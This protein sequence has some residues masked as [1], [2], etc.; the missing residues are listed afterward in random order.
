MISFIT[1]DQSIVEKLKIFLEIDSLE[2]IKKSDKF[3]MVVVILSS[4]N[5]DFDHIRDQILT[6]QEVPTMES[7]TTPSSCSN[8]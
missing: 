6:S 5:L 8:Y 1:D 2:K 3:Y 7:L 4:M